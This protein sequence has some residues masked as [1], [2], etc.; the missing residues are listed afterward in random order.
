MLYT[1]SDA[2]DLVYRI[3]G[4]TSSLLVDSS[5]QEDK[6]SK[7]AFDIKEFYRFVIKSKIKTEIELVNAFDA[8]NWTFVEASHDVEILKT[9]KDFVI[10][11]FLIDEDYNYF[12]DVNHIN[13]EL[14]KIYDK[15]LDNTF[16]ED[17]STIEW[18]KTVKMIESRFLTWI[19]NK[20]LKQ[21]LELK[22]RLLTILEAMNEKEEINY[23]HKYGLLINTF[24][25]LKEYVDDYAAG[26]IE[27]TAENV[28]LYDKYL[29]S[30]KAIN[31][32]PTGVKIKDYL[33][34]E[35]MVLQV[36]K[37]PDDASLWEFDFTSE[38][39]I[40][41]FLAS[42]TNSLV[43]SDTM[44]I[45]NAKIEMLRSNGGWE[46]DLKKDSVRNLYIA[47]TQSQEKIKELIAF[48]GKKVNNEMIDVASKLIKKYTSLIEKESFMSIDHKTAFEMPNC[49]IIKTYLMY[50]GKLIK[51]H[52]TGISDTFITH[53]GD[54]VGDFDINRAD[55]LLN[56]ENVNSIIRALQEL[57]SEIKDYPQ[58]VFQ[59]T[60]QFL[61]DMGNII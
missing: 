9:M 36:K 56:F 4:K 1:A 55:S 2:I 43:T 53:P 27:K 23:D 60:I 31:I 18:H 24:D 48:N 26:K 54:A 40:R 45:W 59:K 37:L 57:D 41:I 52:E 49:S 13:E 21:N 33:N 3:I 35:Q 47:L 34:H 50:I 32:L 17:K 25:R 29:A 22:D 12:L 46:I 14:N 61:E 7:I 5:T 38:L 10:E 28:E 19:Q 8:F 15:S 58:E 6:K 16:I 30:M 51:Y 42:L 20:N 39:L 44:S 11:F